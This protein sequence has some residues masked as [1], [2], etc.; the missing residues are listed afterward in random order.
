M[1]CFR[2]R[3]FCLPKVF[4]FPISFSKFLLIHFDQ[5]LERMTLNCGKVAWSIGWN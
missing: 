5:D 1:A 2:L 4:D 3:K